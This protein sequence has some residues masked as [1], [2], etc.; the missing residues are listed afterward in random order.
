MKIISII[1]ARMG[2][3]RFPGKPMAFIKGIPMIE[4]VYNQ[5]KKNDLNIE[6]WVATPDNEIYEHMKSIKGNVVITS[7]THERASD[8]CCE[9]IKIIEKKNNKNFDIVLMVQG[10]EPMINKMMIKQS[11]QPML[12]NNEIYVTN[13][14]GKI[15]EKNDFTNKNT[16]KVVCDNNSYAMYF[17]RSPIPFMNDEKMFPKFGKQVAIIPFEK[18]FLFE[19]S[20]MK[21]TSLEIIESVDMLRILE[22]GKK[23]F[24]APTN[25]SNQ[26]VDTEED[27]NIVNKLI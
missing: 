19:Y 11:L 18:N 10:D 21:Q 23:V 12:E 13:L 17:S 22:N 25:F 24:M 9:A 8:R 1:P 3:S 6:V 16:I 20:S 15:S 26:S 2:S 14:I 4:F 27:L 7:N 5:V